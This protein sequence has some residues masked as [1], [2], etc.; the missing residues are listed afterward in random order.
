MRSEFKTTKVGGSPGVIWR[1]ML[2][3]VLGVCCLG[4]AGV[5]RGQSTWNLNA[6]GAWGTAGNWSPSGVPSSIGAN[7]TFGSVITANRL[8]NVG[9]ART[10]GSITFNDDNNY[11]LGTSGSLVMDVSSGSASIF[12]PAANTG[13]HTISQGIAL[14]DPFVITNQSSGGLTLNGIILSLIHI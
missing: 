14:N 12:L 9:A 11:T 4:M 8:I 7:V 3:V 1:R 10:V 13:S 5:A 6:D 2:T